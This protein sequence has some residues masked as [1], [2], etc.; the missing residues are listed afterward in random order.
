MTIPDR[1]RAYRHRARA[2]IG[3]RAGHVLLEGRLERQRETAFELGDP[4]RHLLLQL[5]RAHVV[6]RV[7]HDLGLAEALGELDGP[8]APGGRAGLV[9]GQHP[10]LRHVAV[11]H[12]ELAPGREQLEQLDRP[13]R[14]QPRLL[15]CPR[16]TPGA[17]AS[18]ARRP[19]G[20][21]R[22][23]RGA[24]RARSGAPRW[25]RR[26]RGSGSTRRSGAPAAPRAERTAGRHRGAVR[27][28]TARPPRDGTRAS[29][30]APRPPG[31]SAAPP[32]RRRPPRRGG[33]GGRDRAR[34]LGERGERPPVQCQAAVGRQG[35]LDGHPRDLVA[36]AHGV[37]L[38]AQHARGQAPVE[39]DRA[40]R[41]PAPRAMTARRASVRWPRRPAARARSRRAARRGRARRRGRSRGSRRR[42][43]RAPRSRRTGCRRSGDAA[44]R[45]RRRPSRPAR[46][47]PGRRAA[48]G[49]VAPPSRWAARRGR[50]AAG[51]AHRA[52]RRDRW[53]APA[54]GAPRCAGRAG[55]GRRAW[56]R[57]PSGGPRGRRCPAAARAAIA[58]APR[59]GR[60]QRPPRP[61]P[62]RA[63]R[64]PRR[65]CPRGG[66]A[67]AG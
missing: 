41:R 6:E 39:G 2:Q 27:G 30:P 36:E 67:G 38:G 23:S 35:L 10:Q 49:P 18:G 50:S 26:C 53:R 63:R 47:L 32:R 12:R 24:P 4:V 33:R 40:R 48:A 55:A 31:R 5:G 60:R 3:V 28:R 56:P 20:E 29:P 21:C 66:R 45:G 62:R 14:L 1:V 57:R 37:A 61:P 13:P 54:R 17:R 25:R 9:A 15:R 46:P 42:R 7:D 58:P 8:L 44:R 51:G 22:P 64:P 59:R 43:P 19:G 11:G 16:T 65:R 52:R 34:A